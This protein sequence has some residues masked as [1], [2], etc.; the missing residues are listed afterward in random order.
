MPGRLSS[1]QM[2]Q[3]SARECKGSTSSTGCQKSLKAPHPQRIEIKPSPSCH[4][5]E[6]A[7]KF[8][9]HAVICY[10]KLVRQRSPRS[11]GAYPEP[12]LAT[13]D[14]QACAATNQTL[15]GSHA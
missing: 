6:V 5:V 8:H 3:N 2:L 14:T 15:R 11:C 12:S 1:S 9:I 13:G 4:A 10:L 7:D